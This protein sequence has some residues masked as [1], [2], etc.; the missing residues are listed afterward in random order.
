[1]QDPGASALR[2]DTY[3]GRERHL[4]L[5]RIRPVPPS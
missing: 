4:Q 1:L 3:P 2:L 5:R